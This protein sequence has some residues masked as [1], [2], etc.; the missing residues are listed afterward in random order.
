MVIVKSPAAGYVVQ[1]YTI[2]VSHAVVRLGVAD[3]VTD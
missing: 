2:T 1:P 3:Q